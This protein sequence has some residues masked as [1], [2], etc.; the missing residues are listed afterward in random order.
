[1]SF[2]LSDGL[3]GV[4]KIGVIA[5]FDLVGENAGEGKW[6]DRHG[7]VCAVS[8]RRRRRWFGYKYC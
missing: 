7:E 1:M 6:V 8:W 4:E 3:S 2:E 5:H